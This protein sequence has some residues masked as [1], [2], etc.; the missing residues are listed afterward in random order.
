MLSGCM[1]CRTQKYHCLFYSKQLYCYSPR[2]KTL[3]YFC[4]NY[5]NASSIYQCN[6][7]VYLHFRLETIIYETSS[8][9]CGV[10]EMMHLI[11]YLNDTACVCITTQYDG[12]GPSQAVSSCELLF[13]NHHE[14]SRYASKQTVRNKLCNKSKY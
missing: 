7:I 11:A 1:V 13:T 6:M 3:Y 8:V 12:S 14:L 4:S 2:I 10:T 5:W 9:C